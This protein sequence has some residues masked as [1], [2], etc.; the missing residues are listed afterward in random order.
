MSKH[1]ISRRKMLLAMGLLGA[2]SVYAQS[3]LKTLLNSLVSGQISHAQERAFSSALK[4]QNARNFVQLNLYGAPSRYFFD[5]PLRPNDSDPFIECSGL[6]NAITQVNNEAPNLSKGAYLDK[7]IRGIN[8]PHLWSYD[9]AKVGG[10]TRPM[11]ELMSNMLMIRGCVMG[12]D[13]HPINCEKQVSPISG[14]YS[15]TGLV[16]DNSSAYFPSISLG[17]SPAN[18][19]FK[20]AR[21]ASA[22]DIPLDSKDFISYLLEVFY[23]QTK[24][25]E[26][27]DVNSEKEI[28]KALGVLKKYSL[29]NQPGAE[30]LYNERVKVE[31]LIKSGVRDFSDA[32]AQLTKK[33]DDLFNRSLALSEIKGATDVAVP[34]LKF[35]AS[36]PN[37]IDIQ[38]GLGTHRYESGFY[39]VEPDLRTV[40]SKVKADNLAKS[41]ALAEFVLSEGLSS[42]ILLVPPAHDRGNLL[43][44]LMVENNMYDAG[45]IETKFN[46]EKNETV[47]N[48]KPG[49]KLAAETKP[50]FVTDSHGF[51]WVSQVMGCNLFYRGMSAC[52]L[53]F[54]DQMKAKKITAGTS[55]FDE[56]VFQFATEFERAPTSDGGGT[57][58]NFLAC[59]TSVFSGI[60]KK[61]EVIGN[62]YAGKKR[63]EGTRLP[64]GTIGTAAPVKALENKKI[65]ITHVSSTLS[66]MLR[67]PKI[68]SRANSLVEVKNGVLKTKIEAAVNVNEET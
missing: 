6:Y 37:N 5:H 14:D 23:E 25:A 56:T 35:P 11:Q 22:I 49:A 15:I 65:A 43:V 40:F 20:S 57:Q 8:M 7:K 48:L 58:H 50:L 44:D 38:S 45:Q 60:I 34:G 55:L 17:Q 62:I 21:G 29:S 19:C 13:G 64:L 33:Y 66:E 42:S 67:V 39:I 59:T 1:S 4:T 31:K 36:A 30:I 12:T 41:F 61:P 27:M 32:S 47:F 18:K 28:E 46:P 16:S 54:I 9:V 68:A 24:I 26:Q 2:E 10:K 52:F 53:E 63:P 3:S 51:G